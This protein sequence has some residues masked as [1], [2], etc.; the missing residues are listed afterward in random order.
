MNHKNET[1]EKIDQ[2]ILLLNKV[3]NNFIDFIDYVIEE[4]SKINKLLK[5]KSK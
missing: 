4:I 3:R 1:N 5:N 2:A